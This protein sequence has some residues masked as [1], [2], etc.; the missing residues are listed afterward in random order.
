MDKTVFITDVDTDLGQALVS[1]YLNKCNIFATVSSEENLRYLTE[2]YNSYIKIVVWNRKSPISS[3]NALIKA[4]T[5]Y[6]AIDNF[7]ILHD[8]A[9]EQLMPNE[10]KFEQIEKSIDMWIKGTVFLIKEIINFIQKKNTGKNIITLINRT[11]NLS[12]SVLQSLT[13]GSLKG[14]MDTLLRLYKKEKFIILGIDSRSDNTKSIA[15]FV[16]KTLEEKGEKLKSRWLRLQPGI[17]PP[18][19]K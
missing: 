11:Q 13:A 5:I 2:K 10:L 4:Q 12:R 15:Q 9:D 17:I 14:L 6:N 7:I 19:K 16:Y 8:P 3:K 1:L 18:F